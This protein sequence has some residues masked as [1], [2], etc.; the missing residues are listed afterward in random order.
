VTV[1]ELDVTL[2]GLTRL[3]SCHTASFQVVRSTSWAS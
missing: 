1:F 3:A 2:A